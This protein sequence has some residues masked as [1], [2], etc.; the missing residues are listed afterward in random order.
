MAIK[1]TVDEMEV[2]RST[3]SGA[4]RD[5]PRQVR[6]GPCGER[7]NLLV[8]DVQPFDFPLPANGVGEA[9]EAIADDSVNALDACGSQRCC[10]LIRDSFH[11]Y[12]TIE[13]VVCPA[14]NAELEK[15][16]TTHL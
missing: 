3:T 10:E 1:Q 8:S 13:V 11:G 6:L 9:I 7:G 5:F 2:A 15:A 16:I 12:L 14:R 4:N